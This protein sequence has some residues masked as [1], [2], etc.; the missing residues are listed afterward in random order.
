MSSSLVRRLR[1]CIS[2]SRDAR[3]TG[4]SVVDWEEINGK[5]IKTDFQYILGE[6]Q[7]LG[8]RM[9]ESLEK[10]GKLRNE[11]RE[12]ENHC[13]SHKDLLPRCLRKVVLGIKKGASTG[14]NCTVYF[15]E[16]KYAKE[17]P[18]PRLKYDG[19]VKKKIKVIH[20]ED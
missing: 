14:E 7:G 1:K 2:P 11:A 8:I 16:S 19:Q 10:D 12:E 17:G 3:F 9:P 20:E 4:A 15:S 6:S 18:Q 5:V 13:Q